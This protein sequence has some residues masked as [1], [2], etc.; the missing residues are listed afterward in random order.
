MDF[1]FELYY[2]SQD[3]PFEMIQKLKQKLNELQILEF[4]TSFMMKSNGIINYNNIQLTTQID[5]LKKYIQEKKEEY[6]TETYGN[7]MDNISL[8]VDIITNLNEMMLNYFNISLSILKQI[9]LYC[10]GSKSDIKHEIYIMICKINIIDTKI[11]KY[12]N[13]IKTLF[14]NNSFYKNDTTEITNIISQ[15]KIMSYSDDID[16][17]DIHPSDIQTIKS[18]CKTIDDLK[19]VADILE[20]KLHKFQHKWNINHSSIMSSMDNLYEDKKNTQKTISHIF[21]MLDSMTNHS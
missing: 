15:L 12:I 5:E 21:K 19:K 2:S 9:K 11:I 8:I 1:N 14:Q 13:K 3:L 20:T 16:I 10:D 6:N 4:D 17:D 18:D 7:L